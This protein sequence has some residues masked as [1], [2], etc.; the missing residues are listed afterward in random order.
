MLLLLRA[1]A[2]SCCCCLLPCVAQPAF[3]A[4]YEAGVAPKPP[5]PADARVRA[6][7]MG[8]V[9]PDSSVVILRH[10]M[11]HKDLTNITSHSID[12]ETSNPFN[13]DDYAAG[14]LV[15]IL[16]DVDDADADG[17]QMQPLLVIATGCIDSVV[18]DEAA[19]TKVYKVR[20]AHTD[21]QQL[22]SVHAG[23]CL[24]CDVLRATQCWRCA[25]WVLWCAGA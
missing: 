16:G 24:V 17:P 1:T 7:N 2:A 6:A 4:L 22:V 15:D 5:V 11:H 21:V 19:G 9:G 25:A 14:A 8:L 12:A 3:G 18:E 20:A 23:S 13:R 10:L